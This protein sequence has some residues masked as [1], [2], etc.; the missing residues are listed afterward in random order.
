M[1]GKA[2]EGWRPLGYLGRE[3]YIVERCRGKVVLHLGFLGETERPLDDRIASVSAPHSLHSRIAGVSSRVVG[4]DIA[5][6]AIR[7]LQAAG[8]GDIA[9]VDV[10]RMDEGT[11]P[12]ELRFDVVVA[13][14]IIEHLSN[15]GLMLENLK[16]ILAP[17]G[18]IIFTTPNA[19]GLP[20]YLRFMMGRFREGT[21]HVQAHSYYT[22]CHL[23]RRHGYEVVESWTSYEERSE[24]SLRRHAMSRMAFRLGKRLFQWKPRLGGTLIVLACLAPAGP[25]TSA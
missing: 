18:E 14:D 22:L 23:L 9:C 3:D 15:P 4:T 10:E 8:V 7:E 1:I 6:S 16:R 25:V 20:N 2:S 13:G 21:D 11:L 19:F 5:D 12:A 24:N 17:D